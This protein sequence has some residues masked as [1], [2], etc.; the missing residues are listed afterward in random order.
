V[1]KENPELSAAWLLLGELA[2]REGHSSEAVDIISRG[3]IH[4]PDDR[5]LLRFKA[6]AEMA[7]GPSLAIPTLN[8]LRELDANDV[9]AAV[10]LSDAYMGTGKAAKAVALLESQ[11]A[12]CKTDADL[13]KTRIALAAAMS[14][15]GDMAGAQEIFA[16]L[17]KASP[18]DPSVLVSEMRMLMDNKLWSQIAQKTD[19]W[20][21]NHKQDTTTPQAV[22]RMLSGVSD[23]EAR[24]TAEHILRDVLEGN[25]E[26][27]DAMSALGTLLQT[28]GRSADA[29]TLYQR[30]LK[31]QPQNLVVINNLAWILCEERNKYKEALDLSQEGLKVAPEYTD[32]IDTRGVAYYRLGQ[33]DRAVQDFRKCIELYLNGTPSATASYF[34]LGRALAKLGQKDE[35][36]QNLSKA[37]QLN[38]DTGGLSPTDLADAQHL[39]E[40][41]SQSSDGKLKNVPVP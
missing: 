31:A 22:A 16:S 9:D 15:N 20:C 6:Y 38:S 27:F 8:A 7:Q 11:V 4:Q 24:S 29:E 25:S 39:V 23:S 13:R 17:Y 1:T 14:R 34:H 26:C 18:N 41:L 32:L 10:M 40:Q 5:N 3:L 21:K 12:R 28:M 35:A 19:L 2:L 36:L 33:I 37:I 30:I